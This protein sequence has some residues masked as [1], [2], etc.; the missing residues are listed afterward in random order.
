MTSELRYVQGATTQEREQHLWNHVRSLEA[1]LVIA[2]HEA[3]E[4]IT[5]RQ[6]DAEEQR[7]KAIEIADALLHYFEPSEYHTRMNNLKSLIK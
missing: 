4:K 3:R 2:E 1:K 5:E 7:D 6:Q